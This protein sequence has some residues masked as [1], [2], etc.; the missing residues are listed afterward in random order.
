[1]GSFRVRPRRAWIFTQ[2]SLYPMLNNRN[3][4]KFPSKTIE[5]SV[6]DINNPDVYKRWRDNKLALYTQTPDLSI[7]IDDPFAISPNEHKNLCQL[8]TRFNMALYSTNKANIADDNIPKSIGQSLGLFTLDRHLCSEESGIAALRFNPDRL[9]QDYIP[10][11]RKPI[12]WHTDGYYNTPEHRINSVLLHCVSAAES[13]GEN[14]VMDPDILYILLREIN[15]EL[16][17]ALMRPEVMTIPAN[18]KDGEIIREAQTGPVFIVNEH[19]RLHMRYTA[20]TRS[21]EWENIPI[22]KEAVEHISR[23]LNDESSPYIIKFRMKPGQGIVC[24]NVLHM[25]SGFNDND[26]TGEARLVYR[27]RYYDHIDCEV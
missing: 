11:S 9:H 13:G 20:R 21:I 17:Q 8:I 22:V 18:E 6:F 25:R 5:N 14:A 26:A 10:Y 24:N 4:N 27:A 16:V 1:M 23:L 19:G 15:P 3:S 12:N 7:S 2:P